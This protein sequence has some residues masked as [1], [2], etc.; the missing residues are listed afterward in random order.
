MF[1]QTY[2]KQL[3]Y[4]FFFCYNKMSRIIIANLTFTIFN[5]I[6]L[7]LFL[8]GTMIAYKYYKEHNPFEDLMNRGDDEQL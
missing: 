3:I 1:T 8:I 6:I 5:F 7:V 2:Y 4:Y